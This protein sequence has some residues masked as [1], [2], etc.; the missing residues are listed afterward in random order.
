MVSKGPYHSARLPMNM[1]T[2]GVK[3]HATG[4]AG[5][6]RLGGWNGFD[7]LLLK[8]TGP[9]HAH[10]ALQLDEPAVSR[11]GSLRLLGTRD[12]DYYISLS[13]QLAGRYCAA[14]R[15]QHRILTCINVSRPYHLARSPAP[16]SLLGVWG[17][18]RTSNQAL[19]TSNTLEYMN[20]RPASGVMARPT[21]THSGRA[22]IQSAPSISL[23]AQEAARSAADTLEYMNRQPASGVLACGGS[24]RKNPLC[25]AG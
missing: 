15:R 11:R 25:S 7:Y 9:G 24:D 22:V 4:S 1:F 2:G 14:Q 8:K 12:I 18:L 19:R 16:D 20:R 23:G 3:W 6:R 5:L 13:Q 21:S 10:L 17:R